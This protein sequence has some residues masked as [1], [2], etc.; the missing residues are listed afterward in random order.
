M[1]PVELE[2]LNCCLSGLP[3]SCPQELAAS[4]GGARGGI[5]LTFG[6]SLSLTPRTVC[7]QIA[8]PAAVGPG[9]Q[10]EVAVQ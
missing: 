8:A 6:S 3:L 7:S 2:P 10:G 4:G 1:G 5:D 9:Q